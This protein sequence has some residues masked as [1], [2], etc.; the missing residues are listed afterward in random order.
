MTLIIAT[1][2]HELGHAAGLNHVGKGTADNQPEE[3]NEKV[4]RY[5]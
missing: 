5:A 4:V 3:T 2:A 1:I